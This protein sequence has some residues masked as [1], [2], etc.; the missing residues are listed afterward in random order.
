MAGPL[1]SYPISEKVDWDFIPLIG[2]SVTTVPDVG[3][4]T[5][6]ATSFAFSLG[7]QV[8]IHVGNKVSFL[9]SADY[10]STKPEFKDYGFEQKIE[11]LSFGLG[12]AYRLK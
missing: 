12:F 9:L 2:Y 8:R 4:G 5:E 10:L 11:T 3:S 6:Q 7:T 1:L